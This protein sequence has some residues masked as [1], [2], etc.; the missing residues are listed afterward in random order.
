VDF[1]SSTPARPWDTNGITVRQDNGLGPSALPIGDGW[2]R[3]VR[4]TAGG[5]CG[6]RQEYGIEHPPDVPDHVQV[7]Y[8]NGPQGYRQYTRDTHPDRFDD[9]DDND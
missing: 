3:V 7:G 6:R 1:E 8:P 4:G 2:Y 5:Q 9:G